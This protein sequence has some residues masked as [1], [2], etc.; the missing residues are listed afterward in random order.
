MWF[1]DIVPPVS[2]SIC[3]AI[4]CRSAIKKLCARVRERE[5]EK[6]NY[7]LPDVL[8]SPRDRRKIAGTTVYMVKF[9]SS[10]AYAVCIISA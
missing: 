10:V 1:Y 3:T 6:E 2:S 7:V 4:E 8:I 5:E 9:I